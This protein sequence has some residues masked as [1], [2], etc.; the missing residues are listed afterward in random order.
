M[1]S[2]YLNTFLNIPGFAEQNDAYI[3]DRL[4]NHVQSPFTQNL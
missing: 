4:S 1:E 2:L 3:D